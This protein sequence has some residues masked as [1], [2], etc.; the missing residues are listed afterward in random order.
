MLQR[1]AS[2]AEAPKLLLGSML[3]LVQLCGAV[4]PALQRTS[5]C[6]GSL[7]GTETALQRCASNAAA[8][9]LLLRSFNNK[10]LNS[11]KVAEHILKKGFTGA[12]TIRSLHGEY[13]VGQS[14]RSRDR[15]EPYGSNGEHGEY[16]EPT[17]E[18]EIENPYTRMVRDAMGSEVAFNYSH[19]NESRFVEE[20]PNPNAAS[21]YSVKPDL[22]K[23][24]S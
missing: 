13:D 8:P 17:Y 4:L 9:K 20:D 1:C 7:I 5:F 21:F 11:D 24:L 19:D 23:Y 18:E 12:Y 6:L 15:V 16:R 3:G 2:N 22:I 14:S 10:F